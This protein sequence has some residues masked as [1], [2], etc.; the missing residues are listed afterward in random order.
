M[1]PRCSLRQPV[2]RGIRE[3]WAHGHED[4][5]HVLSRAGGFEQLLRKHQIEI[6][7]NEIPLPTKAEQA[8]DKLYSCRCRKVRVRTAT[9]FEATC[10]RCHAQF[11]PGNHV[12]R[13]GR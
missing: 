1:L 12:A 3:G 8:G 9:F 10:S 7:A 2:P 6:P 13:A 4:R 11:R 5:H